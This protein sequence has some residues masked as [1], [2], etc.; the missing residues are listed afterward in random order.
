ME[1]GTISTRLKELIGD[2]GVTPYEI[3]KM[4]GISQATLSRILNNNTTKLN[5]QNVTLLSEYFNV[6]YD[7]LS[8]GKGEKKD[9]HY[10]RYIPRTGKA[11]D[12]SGSYYT[13]DPLIDSHNR[14][15]KA[16][17][18]MAESNRILAENNKRVAESNEKVV[19]EILRVFAGG[20]KREE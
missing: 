11:N 14:L 6:S 7:W 8:T 20:P 13:G 1:S 15:A 17:E 12:V 10:G 18:T 4:T 19:N 3:S 16:M 2:K 5:I 9:V